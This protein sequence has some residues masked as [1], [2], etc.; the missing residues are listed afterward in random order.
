MPDR[1]RI[2]HLVHRFDC[3]GLQN[4]MVNIIARLPPDE[5]DHMVISLTDSTEFRQRLPENVGL[6]ELNKPPGKSPAYLLRLWKMLRTG[7]YDILHTR[8]LPCIEG[9]VA[10]LLAGVPVRIHGEHGW[11]VY[12]LDGSRRRYRLL[13]RLLGLVIDRFV[14]LSEHLERYLTVDAGIAASKIVRICNGVDTNRFRPAAAN[15]LPTSFVVG[16]VGRLEIVK[17]YLTLARAFALLASAE[18][19]SPRLVLVGDGTQRQAI[20]GF[21]EDAHVMDRCTL[22]GEREDI[23]ELMRQFSVFVLPS[24]AEGISNT[25][26]EAMASGL[27]V[28]ATD[29]GGNAELVVHGVTGFLV[30]AGEPAAIAARLREYQGDPALA[31]RHGSAGRQRAVEHFSLDGMVA[32]YRNLYRDGMRRA[33][34]LGGRA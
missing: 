33:G 24:R 1:I 4:G 3:G 19:A 14:V 9:Q 2:A 12:D 31:A 15:E 22:A 5:F 21:L 27:P 11:D 7:R 13:R 17:D 28:I 20:L 8:N 26:L 6:A 23:P 10:G 32:A 18:G 25:I 30:P 34:R 16:S 29:V